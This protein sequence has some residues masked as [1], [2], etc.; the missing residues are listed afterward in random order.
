M[1]VPGG[2]MGM[3]AQILDMYLLHKIYTVSIYHMYCIVYRWSQP[4]LPG[5]HMGMVSNPGYE[6]FTQNIHRVKLSYVL[7]RGGHI[8]MIVHIQLAHCGLVSKQ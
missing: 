2:H 3:V 7:Y 4:G 8:R 6:S 1:V 5:G